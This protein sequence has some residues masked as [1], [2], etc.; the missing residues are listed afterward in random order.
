MTSSGRFSRRVISGHRIRQYA[1]QAP[2]DATHLADFLRSLTGPIMLAG[3]SYGDAV[4]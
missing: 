1:G 3:H 4:I 2:G